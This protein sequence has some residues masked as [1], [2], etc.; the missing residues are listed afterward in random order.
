MMEPH[1]LVLVL[2]MSLG[3]GDLPVSLSQDE[4]VVAAAPEEKPVRPPR[5]GKKDDQESKPQENPLREPERMPARLEE[6]GLPWVDFDWFELQPRLGIAAFSSDYRIGTSFCFSLVGHVPIPA[7]SLGG[8]PEAEHFG[9]FAEVNVIPGVKRDLNPAPSHSS[10]T[11]FLASA[12]VDYT[13][14]RNQTLYLAAEVGVQYGYYGGIADL[15]NGIA[16]VVG[17]AGGVYLGKGMTLTGGPEVIL[18]KSSSHII[19]GS[20]GLLIEF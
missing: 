8:N 17:F 1:A 2:A 20:L 11:I 15:K 12:G 16:P 6:E 7:I 10:G 5:Q 3:D 18:G 14:L 13:F 19:L 4:A 9:L